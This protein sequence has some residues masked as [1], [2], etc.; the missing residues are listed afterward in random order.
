M[1][2]S[3]YF[4]FFYKAYY[5]GFPASCPSFHTVS[6]YFKR[7]FQEAQKLKIFF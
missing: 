4:I 6:R 5:A 1:F 2:S 3:F 7:A